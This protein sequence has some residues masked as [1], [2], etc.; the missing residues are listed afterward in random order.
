MQR[1]HE[2]ASFNC[3]IAQVGMLV[4]GFNGAAHRDSDAHY[5]LLSGLV[6]KDPHAWGKFF[7]TELGLEVAYSSNTFIYYVANYVEH[8]QRS[9]PTFH[10]LGFY[11][12]RR[13]YS[14]IVASVKKVRKI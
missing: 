6:Q 8:F 14:A 11:F 3:P 9:S 2:L 1:E 13:T 5:T 12:N 10:N 7:F 4:I